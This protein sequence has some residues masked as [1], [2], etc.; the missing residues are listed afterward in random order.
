M[1][2]YDYRKLIQTA[3]IHDWNTNTLTRNA[4]RKIFIKIVL[5]IIKIQ[6]ET[7]CM[8]FRYFPMLTQFYNYI[9]LNIL[10]KGIHIFYNILNLFLR[11]PLYLDKYILHRDTTNIQ[12]RRHHHHIKH[13][14]VIKL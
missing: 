13:M 7:H 12:Y 2:N 9:M 4:N 6:Q 10:L 8:Q 3:K 5:Q 11:S 1:V 14:M